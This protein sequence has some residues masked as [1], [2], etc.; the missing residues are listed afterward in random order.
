M[1][2]EVND[3][4]IQVRPY[5]LR[6]HHRLR[7]LDPSHIDKLISIRG[8]VIRN[9]DIIPEMKEAS[10]KCFKCHYV[11]NEFI[12]RG[13]IQEPDTCNS[14]KSRYSFQLIHNNCF[15]SDKQHVKM[16]ETPESVPEGETPYT[17]HL[18]AYEDLV[19]YVKPGDRVEVIG[20]YKAMGV[21]VDANKRTLKNVYRTYIDVINYIK[22]DRKRFNVDMNNQ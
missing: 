3:P 22:S 5:N 6:T 19:D 2:A 10:F 12:Q 13:R 16:Q 7:D 9:S 21:R 8:I 20:I 14:C 11:H 18:C 17:V 15:F 4:I 1:N